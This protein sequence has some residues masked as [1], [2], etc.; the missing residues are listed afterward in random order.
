MTEPVVG[1]M[2]RVPSELATESTDPAPPPTQV[3]PT[4]KQPPVRLM[5]RAKVEEADVPVTL[6]PRK[7]APPANV[8]VAV[9]LVAWKY[10]A[11]ICLQTSRPPAKVEVPVDVICKAEEVAA[12]T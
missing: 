6:S 2:V 1:E 4:A 9:V 5:P 12:D 11:A 8:D 7:D 10:G 3:P